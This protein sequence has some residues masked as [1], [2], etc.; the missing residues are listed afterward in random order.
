VDDFVDAIR[1]N[2]RPNADIEEGHRTVGLVHLANIAIRLGR[3]LDFDPANE[4]IVGDAE[5]SQLLSRNYRDGGH[6]AIP[7]GV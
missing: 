4:Q 3:S 2:R 7:Q 5:A 1:N 6:W